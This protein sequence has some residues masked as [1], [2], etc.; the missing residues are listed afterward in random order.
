MKSEKLA[1]ETFVRMDRQLDLSLQ[2]LM[3][4]TDLRAISEI[5]SENLRASEFSEIW[6][7]LE[8]HKVKFIEGKMFFRTHKELFCERKLAVPEKL[9]SEVLLWAHQV[10]GHPGIPRTVWFFLRNFYAQVTRTKLF[11]L[12]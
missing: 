9:L 4:K 8:A 12:S 11:E 2:L 1:H 5:L 3:L 7:N 6:K 10:N